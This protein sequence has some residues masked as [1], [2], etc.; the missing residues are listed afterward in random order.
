MKTKEAVFVLLVTIFLVLAFLPFSSKLPDGLEKVAS[1]KG[2]L[3]KADTA[4][5][6][7][8]P[9]PDYL[10]PGIK[11]EKTAQLA[12]AIAGLM[13]VFS[14]SYIVTLALK[15]RNKNVKKSH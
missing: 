11:N 6:I 10:W 13:I 3:E 12:A 14:L 2:F 8:S 7:K 1:E 4:S 15:R 9:V 5:P